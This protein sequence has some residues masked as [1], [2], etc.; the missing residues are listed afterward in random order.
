MVRLPG[1]SRQEGGGEIHGAVEWYAAC[2]IPVD[3]GVYIVVASP[4]GGSH[5][6]V[7]F[8]GRH[9]GSGINHRLSSGNVELAENICVFYHFTIVEVWYI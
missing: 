6:H 3:M 5:C 9:F 7:A 8:L 1:V 2:D 4:Y